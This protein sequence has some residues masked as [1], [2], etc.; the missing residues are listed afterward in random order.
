MTTSIRPATPA[1]A[2][3]IGWAVVTAVGIEIIETI[4]SVEAVAEMFADLARLDDTQYS[5]RNT[6]V[7]VA[8]DGTPC[9]VCIAYDGAGLHAMREHFFHAVSSR[10]GLDMTDIADETD[11][12]EVYL[13]T[14]AVKPKYRRHGVARALIAAAADRAAAIGKP[15][16]LLVDKDNDRA[17]RLYE[18]CGFTFVGERPFAYT[19]MDH[20]QITGKKDMKS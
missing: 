10:F 8:P 6:L 13:D 2:P 1:D 5:W 11:P 19:L 12:S 15:L 20:L 3:L 16:G 9:G 18:S 17:R 7:A 4:G 14:L